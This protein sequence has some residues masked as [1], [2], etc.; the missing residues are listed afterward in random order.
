MIAIRFKPL[1]T[2]GYSI[3]LDIYDKGKRERKVLGLWVSKD[4]SKHKYISKEDT[5]SVEKARQIANLPGKDEIN[6]NFRI[7]L[8]NQMQFIGRQFAVRALQAEK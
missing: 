7:F 3:Y 5:T 8:F 6:R 1:R 4:Y 2:G